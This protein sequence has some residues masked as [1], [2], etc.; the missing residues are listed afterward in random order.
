M[1]KI[2]T[3]PRHGNHF[4][5]ENLANKVKLHKVAES[6]D[7]NEVLDER[8]KWIT[9][10]RHPVDALS[11]K[12]IFDSKNGIYDKDQWIGEPDQILNQKIAKSIKDYI[13]F[14]DKINSHKNVIVIDF[15]DLVLHPQRIISM[16]C[17][18]IYLNPLEEDFEIVFPEATEI[19]E[20]TS[21]IDDSYDSVKG[22]VKN[23]PDIE[24]ALAI[25]NLVLLKKQGVA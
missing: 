21:I 16:L 20:P 7:L 6:H 8:F 3:F 14:Y 11:S 25:Y 23:H 2:V 4:L 12:M 17:H 13:L 22:S 15:E 5:I 18:K 10:A 24:E 9:I 1:N 19:F